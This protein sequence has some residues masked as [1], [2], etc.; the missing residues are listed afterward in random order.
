MT[1]NSKAILKALSTKGC[2]KQSVYRN[3]LEYFDVLKKHLENIEKEQ[4]EVLE[5]IDTSVVVEYKELGA[6][7]ASLKFGG[8]M[9]VFSMHTN[10]FQF[11]DTHFLHQKKYVQED[12]FRAYCGVINIY[13]FLADSYKYNRMNDLGYLLGRIF[14]NKDNHFYVEGK[15]QLGFLFNDLETNIL[16]EKRLLEIIEIAMIYAIDFDLNVPPFDQVNII[17]LGQ[18]IVSEGNIGTSTGKRLG[19]TYKNEDKTAY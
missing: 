13:N 10:V 17:T 4:T 12:P 2:L 11:D 14:I 8:D 19:F 1:E 9:L 16:D 15:Q 3:T 7:E 5:K 18:K 6:F